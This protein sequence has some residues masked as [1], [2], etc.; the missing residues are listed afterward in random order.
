MTDN[1][2]MKT[3]ATEKAVAFTGHREISH[4]H[5]EQVKGTA[6]GSRSASHPSRSEQVLLRHGTRF[7]HDGS[8]RS[9]FLKLGIPML[10]LVAV[11]PFKGTERFLVHGGAATLCLY[12]FQGRRC[13]ASE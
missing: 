8:R 4:I 1:R 3:K 2:T 10:K 5:Q 11:V 6:E 12:P 7:R 13:G 9:P